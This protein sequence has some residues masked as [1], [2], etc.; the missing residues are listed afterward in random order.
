MSGCILSNTP[1][2]FTGP[3]DLV[4]ALG[5][6]IFDRTLHE[7]GRDRLPA[8]TPGSVVHER[9]LIALEVAQ[10]LG[11]VPLEAADAS[12]VT[13]VLALCPAAQG[14]ELAPAPRPA[15]VPQAPLRSFDVADRSTGEA[16]VGRARTEAAGGLQRV[17]EPHGGVPPVQYG[18]CTRQHLALQ[19]PQPGIAVGPHGRR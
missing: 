19:P 13:P 15:A 5:G 18:C 1:P 7:R 12:H 9:I 11:D 10:Q 2:L 4:Q 16:S 3:S 17:F 6:D 8:S 14:S